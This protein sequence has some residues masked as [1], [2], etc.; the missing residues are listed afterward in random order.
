M[1][2]VWDSLWATPKRTYFSPHEEGVISM[3]ISPDSCYIVTLSYSVPQTISLW[4]I[5]N[6]ESNEPIVS[7]TFTDEDKKF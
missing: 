2:V 3:D 6:E 4:D 5:S 7:S 1:L